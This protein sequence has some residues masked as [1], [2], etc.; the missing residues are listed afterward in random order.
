MCLG[1]SVIIKGKIKRYCAR[2][3]YTVPKTF[4]QQ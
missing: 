2:A 1:A 4:P 3:A